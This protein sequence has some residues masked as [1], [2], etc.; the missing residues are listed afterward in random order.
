M[1]VVMVVVLSDPFRGMR[2]VKELHGNPTVASR[3]KVWTRGQ[4]RSAKDGATE[5]LGYGTIQKEVS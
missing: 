2:S 5:R 3:P 1:C 4:N